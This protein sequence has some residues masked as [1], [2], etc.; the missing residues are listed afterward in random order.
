MYPISRH[1]RSHHDKS[2]QLGM[3]FQHP[4]DVDAVL[5][6]PSE[7]REWMRLAGFTCH[8][9]RYFLYFPEPI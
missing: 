8:A 1:R 6:K 5:L 9:P 2:L 7:A 4:V 3:A